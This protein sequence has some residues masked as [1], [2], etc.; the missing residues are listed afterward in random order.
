M[1]RFAYDKFNEFTEP[2]MGAA[3]ITKKYTMPDSGRVI[4]FHVFLFVMNYED[5]GYGGTGEV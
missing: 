1:T 5:L 4:E 3:F 2:T